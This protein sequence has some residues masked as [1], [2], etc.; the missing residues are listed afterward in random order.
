MTL[1]IGDGRSDRCVAQEADFVFAKSGLIDF[2]EKKQLP[3]TA[4]RDFSHASLL[5]GDLLDVVPTVS[6]GAQALKETIYG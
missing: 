1:V 3:F 4:F 5:L 6:A 2:C